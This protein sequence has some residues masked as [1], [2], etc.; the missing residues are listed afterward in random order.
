MF[1]KDGKGGC[2]T[3]GYSDE[4]KRE[5][6]KRM[7]KAKKGKSPNLTEEQKRLKNEKISK[8]LKGKCSERKLKSL[9]E[10]RKKIHLE[11]FGHTS[12]ETKQKIREKLIGRIG[13]NNGERTKFINKIELEEYL[14]NGWKIGQ[15]K[16]KKSG[17]GCNKRKWFTNGRENRLI[18]ISEIG[19]LDDSWKEGKT[20]RNR[21]CS[22]YLREDGDSNENK[23]N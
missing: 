21:I 23:I 20:D 7:S 19:S 14:N 12:E 4:Q 9:E 8:A 15:L 18:L 10:N 5:Y 16:H 2:T 3:R 11:N 22:N 17:Y 1:M 13:I 6:G